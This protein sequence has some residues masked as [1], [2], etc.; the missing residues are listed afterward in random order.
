[1]PKRYLGN[2]ITDTPASPPSNN[3][4]DTSVP[5]VWSLSEAKAY[6]A[7]GVW[8]TS[9]NVSPRAL[10]MGGEYG[11]GTR[12]NTVDSIQIA[13]TG[14]ATDFGDLSG[15]GSF[16][17]G[18][19]SSTRGIMYAG[20]QN[21][22]NEIQYFTI[23]SSG[24]S[25]DFGDATNT[26]TGN[27]GISNETRGIS[28]A[29][30]YGGGIYNR[31]E[32][33]TI[34]STGNASNF[35][36]DLTLYASEREGCGNAT[37]G[38]AAGGYGQSTYR[39]QIAYIT[40]ASTGNATDFGDLGAARRALGAMSTDTRAVS[41]AGYNGSYQNYCE[42]ITIASTGNATFFGRSVSY[43]ASYECTSGGTRGVAVG[44]SKAVTGQTPGSSTTIEYNTITT[45]GNSLDFGDLTQSRTRIA[46]CSNSHGG[47]Q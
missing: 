31:I 43:L 30:N 1:M 23:A 28:Y 16:G 17:A 41:Y 12:V 29:G 39:N 35:G 38:I 14:N 25:T 9:G 6:T 46:G 20:G 19:S 21:G 32:Y 24:N 4:E 22:S 34:A 42:Y 33:I 47:L 45:L 8:P 15:I 10:F 5:G 2:I 36:N 7:A 11:G 26:I 13:T 18:V 27:G 37:R 3:Y 40:I 44:G